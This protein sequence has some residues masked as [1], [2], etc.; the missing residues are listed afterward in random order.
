MG[1]LA[2]RM[3]PPSPQDRPERAFRVV[4][5]R[6]S[7]PWWDLMRGGEVYVMRELRGALRGGREVAL[8]TARRLPWPFGAP[9]RRL[10]KIPV[11]GRGAIV[12]R[13]YEST[14][15]LVEPRGAAPRATVFAEETG[16]PSGGAALSGGDWGLIP[17]A[18]P[19]SVAISR[20]G[21]HA[22]YLIEK[23]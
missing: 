17:L 22:R 3:D 4:S 21:R 8:K 1:M 18:Q 9:E 2:P 5:A 14:T 12:A 13:F 10:I 16:G 19:A 15:P 6:L 7:G 20:R 11:E 23:G